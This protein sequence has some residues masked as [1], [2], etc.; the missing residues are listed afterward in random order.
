MKKSIS[1]QPVFTI[2]KVTDW[3]K[4]SHNDPGATLIQSGLKGWEALQKIKELNKNDFD[5][6]LHPDGCPIGRYKYCTQK[7]WDEDRIQFMEQCLFK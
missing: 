2:Y 5:G 7:Q 1:D 6:P 4:Y 3:T